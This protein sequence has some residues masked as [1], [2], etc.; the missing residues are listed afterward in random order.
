MNGNIKAI[1]ISEAVHAVQPECHFLSIA[2]LASGRAFCAAGYRVPCH[3]CP[4]DICFVQFMFSFSINFEI[5]FCTPFSIISSSNSIYIV[6]TRIKVFI[7]KYFLPL[8]CTQSIFKFFNSSFK[9]VAI[10]F[11]FCRD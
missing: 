8:S 6:I 4:G 1:Y 9:A 7:P 2:V 10:F 11:F 3:V 5:Y